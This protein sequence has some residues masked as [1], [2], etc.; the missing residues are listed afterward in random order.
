MFPLASCNYRPSLR[1]LNCLSSWERS[2]E[3]IVCRFPFEREWAI[4]CT[5][6]KKLTICEIEN[7]TTGNYCNTKCPLLSATIII[8][9][10]LQHFGR[11]NK[12]NTSTFV[13]ATPRSFLIKSKKSSA[14]FCLD[15]IVR[16]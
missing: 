8:I 2:P 14:T 6:K 12:I 9:L 4:K 15:N 10:I 5:E 11:R 3:V 1:P 16:K 7:S 13:D